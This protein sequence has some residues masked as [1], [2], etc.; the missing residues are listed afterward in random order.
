MKRRLINH[1]P[2]R[3]VVVQHGGVGRH[4]QYVEQFPDKVAS[5]YKIG[6]IAIPVI[7]V[8]SACLPKV[9]ILAVYL[10]IFVEKWSRI[11]CY[12]LMFMVI[13]NV[14]GNI[15]PLIYKCDPISYGWDPTTPGGW[16]ADIEPRV[17]YVS[18]I[19]IITDVGMLVLPIPVIWKLHTNKST[20]FGLA[21]VFATGSV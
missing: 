1:F 6:L 13:A 4:L 9:S 2:G 14:I 17:R 19:N 11:A 8:I 12:V 7:Y 15:P 10:R 16:C 5:Y 20:K 21:C 18:L 3:V